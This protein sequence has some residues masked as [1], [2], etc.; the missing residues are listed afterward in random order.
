MPRFSETLMDHFQA[1]R[2]AGRMETPDVVG[3]AGV[4]GQGRY[5]VL[6]VRIAD[7][8]IAK[9]QFDCHGCGVTIACGS[10]LTELITGRSVG[11]CTKITA[12]NLAD[13][14][15]GGPADRGDCPEFAMHALRHVLS[16]IASPLQTG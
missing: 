12:G 5:L 3:L 14:L 16:Q 11:E 1:P 8:R 4:P 9:A 15:D 10:A 7:R 2:N 6:Y 13:A